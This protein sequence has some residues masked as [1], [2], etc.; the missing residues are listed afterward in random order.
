MSVRKTIDYNLSADEAFF[1]H[2][3][4]LHE[5][6]LPPKRS[7]SHAIHVSLRIPHQEEAANTRSTFAAVEGEAT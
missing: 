2:L 1:T 6:F 4:L 3:F 7:L 5:P